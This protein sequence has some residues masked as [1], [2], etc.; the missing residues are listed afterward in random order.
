M[1]ISTKGYIPYKMNVFIPNQKEF[2][3]LYQTIYLKAIELDDNR[4]V[5]GISV[6][7]SFFKENGVI[8]DLDEEYRREKQRQLKLQELLNKI[9]NTSD[10]LS[11]NNLDDV[12][13]SNFKEKHNTMNIDSSFNSLLGFIDQVF[14]ISDR[15]TVLRNGKLVGTFDTDSLLRV[16]LIAKMIGRSL[17]DLDDMSSIKLESSKDLILKAAQNIEIGNNERRRR[18]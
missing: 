13:A 16:E 5:Q 11:L 10:S 12:V 17:S 8:T 9:I 18:N 15:I 7:N 6:D 3:E 2:Y 14:E 4:L 1:I